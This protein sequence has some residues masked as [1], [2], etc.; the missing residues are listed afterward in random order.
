MPS[1]VNSVALR[2]N[3]SEL[4]RHPSP[5]RNEAGVARLSTEVLGGHGFSVARDAIGNLL[6][7]R[8]DGPLIMLNAHMDTTQDRRDVAQIRNGG[9]LRPRLDLNYGFDDKVGVAIILTLA[10]I[11]HLSF[12]VLLTVQEEIGMIGAEA[13]APSSYDDIT[14]CLS[15]DRGGY[16]QMVISIEGRELAPASWVDGVDAALRKGGFVFHRTE[17]L[18]C[19]A[20]HISRHLPTLNFSVGYYEWH[21]RYEFVK[22]QEAL[23]TAKAMRW[24]IENPDLMASSAD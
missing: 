11:R 21:T 2:E 6:A 7:R 9:L 5:S 4:I 22:V 16:D 18:V 15:L 8:G 20:I 10:G 3:L 17:G 12:G 19:D 1:S 14:C 24:L 23:R 13:V